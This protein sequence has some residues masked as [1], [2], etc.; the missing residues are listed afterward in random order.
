M[1]QAAGDKTS[2]Q[3]R[4]QAAD[5][6]VPSPKQPV[7]EPL[8]QFD[9]ASGFPPQSG[10]L[11]DFSLALIVSHEPVGDFIPGAITTQAYAIAVQGTDRN[12][13]R[14]GWVWGHR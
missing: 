14:L 4:L 11:Q 9:A 10:I 7:A 1:P 5:A 13:G 8:K 12:A 2:F 3:D 6:L